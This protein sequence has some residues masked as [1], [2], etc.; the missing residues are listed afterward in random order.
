MAV[1]L[2][3]DPAAIAILL[4]DQQNDFLHADGAYARS[5]TKNNHI[6]ELPARLQPVA[7]AARA[8]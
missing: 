3:S 5:G 1:D 4:V 2:G 6:A 7:D 8:A